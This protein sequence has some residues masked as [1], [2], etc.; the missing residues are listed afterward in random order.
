MR[1]GTATTPGGHYGV[2]LVRGPFVRLAAHARSVRGRGG[3]PVLRSP[4]A[5]RGRASGSGSLQRR[6]RPEPRA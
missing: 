2:K 1:D 4:S 3:V 6:R 5:S